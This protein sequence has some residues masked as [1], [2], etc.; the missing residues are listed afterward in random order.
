MSNLH[1][2]PN[3]L[4][5]WNESCNVLTDD[6]RCPLVSILRIADAGLS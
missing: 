2:E 6:V 5:S 3:E 4:S 1:D